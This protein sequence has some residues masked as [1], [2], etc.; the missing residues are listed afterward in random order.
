MAAAVVALAALV[1]LA[2]VCVAGER[3]IGPPIGQAPAPELIAVTTGNAGEVLLEWHLDPAPAGLTGWQYRHQVTP[4]QAEIKPDAGAWGR[5]TTVPG[6]ASARSHRV[7]GL[8]LRLHYFEVRAVAGS[9][10]GK[11][12][13]TVRGGPAYVGEDGIPQM[14]PGDIIEGGRTWRIHAGLTVVDVPA[15][16][17]LVGG[18]VALSGGRGVVSFSDLATGATQV[19]DTDRAEGVG[20]YPPDPSREAAQGR[21]VDAI[22]DQIL[23]SARLAAES[24]RRLHLT[25]LTPSANG[26]LSASPEAPSY[27]PGT[28]VTVT[29]TPKYGYRLTAWGGDCFGTAASSATCTLTMDVDRTVSAIFGEHDPL[30]L[31]VV[32]DGSTDSLLIEWTGGPENVSKWQYRVKRHVNYSYGEWIDIPNSGAATRSHRLTGLGISSP[33]GYEVRPVVGTT[34]GAASDGASGRTQTP[35]KYPRLRP[36][37]IAE[38]DGRTEWQVHALGFVI[39]IPDGV[40]LEAGYGRQ[41]AVG[42]APVTVTL[43]PSGGSVSFSHEG[44]VLSRH[45]PAAAPGDANAAAAASDIGALLDEIITSLRRL[46]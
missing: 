9:R 35:G 45:V 19:V 2:A 20:R 23:A 13:A 5:W 31:I 27:R 39:T 37:T 26:G 34:P 36:G 10:T 25:L 40:R 8:A 38:G 17:R 33:Y 11:A 14:L 29:A 24:Q 41:P 22:F 4:Y 16:T 46:D 3:G 30:S 18:R 15:G 21:D 43:S 28:P 44:H 42:Q 12:A 7:T 32:S 6:G 1:A